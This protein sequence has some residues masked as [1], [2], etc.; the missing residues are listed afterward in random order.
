MI[1][2]LQAGVVFRSVLH[3]YSTRLHLILNYKVKMGELKQ[4]ISAQTTSKS[5]LG[6]FPLMFS[7]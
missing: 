2:L 4:I 6:N 5:D 3:I 7:H 1:Q